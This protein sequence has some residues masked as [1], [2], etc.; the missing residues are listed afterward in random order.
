MHFCNQQSAPG[1]AARPGW[2]V[3]TQSLQ[4]VFHQLCSEDRDGTWGFFLDF[5]LFLQIIKCR[6]PS[7]CYLGGE[8]LFF[9]TSWGL[10]T[11][12]VLQDYLR[13][14]FLALSHVVLRKLN[15]CLVT[16][17]PV[18][19]QLNSKADQI[20]AQALCNS[21]LTTPHAERAIWKFSLCHWPDLPPCTVRGF[22]LPGNLSSS[23]SLELLTWKNI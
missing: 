18:N 15:H 8:F 16:Q 9:P 19:Q 12:F 14:R 20:P 4:P 21:L 7:S 13:N 17:L 11:H 10:Q 22:F 5:P 3:V 6:W 1:E 23:T 2:S